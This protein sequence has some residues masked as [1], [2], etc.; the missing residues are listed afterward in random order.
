MQSVDVRSYESKVGLG[1]LS[2]LAVNDNSREVGVWIGNFAGMEYLPNLSTFTKFTLP[3]GLNATCFDLR[4]INAEGDA[5]LNC[6]TIPNGPEEDPSDLLCLVSESTSELTLGLNCNLIPSFAVTSTRKSRILDLSGRIYVL[7]LSKDASNGNDKT[8]D[9]ITVYYLNNQGKFIFVNIIDGS[10]LTNPELSINDFVVTSDHI[11]IVADAIRNRLIYYS[12]Y[13]S[14]EVY[15]L[16]II[17]L[18]STPLALS[19]T[20]DNHL[21]VATR[22]AIFEHDATEPSILIN[23]Y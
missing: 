6:Q 13:A 16:K 2:L 3:S 1:V 10:Q 14:N 9:F 11:I 4:S 17:S 21:I 8:L 5:V 18:S 7:S 20:K 12:Y 23:K 19:Y 15:L 22:E